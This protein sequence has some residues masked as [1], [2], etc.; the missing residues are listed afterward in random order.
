MLRAANE[1]PCLSSNLESYFSKFMSPH[2]YLLLFFK[3]VFPSDFLPKVEKNNALCN[4]VNNN[5]TETN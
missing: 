2:L 4:N 5:N 3:Y 1:H